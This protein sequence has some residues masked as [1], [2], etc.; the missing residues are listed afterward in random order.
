M[1]SGLDEIFRER[2]AAIEAKKGKKKGDEKMNTIKYEDFK[3]LDIR[4]GEVLEAERIK[5]SDKLLRLIVDI[6]SEQRQIVA[7]IAMTHTPEDLVGRHIVVLA[8]LEPAKLFGVESQGML[9]AADLGDSAVLLAP[10]KA[11]PPG[12]KIR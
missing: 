1:V 12:T 8:N 9:L 5:G 6:G 10:E 7:G 3:N 2:I 11:A 4:V